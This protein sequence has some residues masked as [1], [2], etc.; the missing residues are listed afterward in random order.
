MIVAGSTGTTGTAANRLT[1]PIDVFIDGN[2]FMYVL[3][4]G[5]SRLQL[6]PPGIYIKN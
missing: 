5:N 4:N 1:F 6:F 2:Q 3:D